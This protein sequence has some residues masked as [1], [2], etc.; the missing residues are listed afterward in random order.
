MSVAY[1]AVL[2]V[3]EDSVLFL[4]GLLLAERRRRGTRKGTRA[5]GTCKQAVLVLRWFLE[6]TRM[7]G[8]GIM[9]SRETVAKL[10][11][12]AGLAGI[13]RRQ[14]RKNQKVEVFSEDLVNRDFL[15]TQPNLLWVC[16][17]TEH[18]TR[19][20]K[21]YCCAVLD[22][23]S[24]KI[25]GWSIDSIQNTTLVVNALDMAI[26]NRNPMPGT[27]FT[28]IHGVQFTSWSFTNRVKQAG[29]MPSLG[30]VG[31]GYD[32]AMMESFWSK[33][34]TELLN[35]RKWKTRTELANEMFQYLEIFHNRQRRHS[36]L[37]YLTPV[38][39]ERLHALQQPA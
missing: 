28:P 38:E 9:V 22:V 26:S 3:S 20:G 15:R 35:R 39:Y 10:M 21:L 16:D 11:Q 17:I 2:E 24:R 19:E 8:M 6:D 18:P 13:P 27:V 32:N 1:T 36:K 30:T 37:G 33:M 29:L 7:L 31:D 34:Q 14:T 5:L 23:F 4:S 12:A 25:V